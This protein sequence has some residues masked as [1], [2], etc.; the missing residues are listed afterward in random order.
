MSHVFL[1]LAFGQNGGLVVAV[2][3]VF[4]FADVAI[5]VVAGVAFAFAVA[6]AVAV[7][8]A[9]LQVLACC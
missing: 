1:Y 2:V 6:E 8:A 7:V 4:F 3:S 9:F 5:R